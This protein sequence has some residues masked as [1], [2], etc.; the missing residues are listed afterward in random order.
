[1]CRWSPL[2]LLP[3]LAACSGKGGDT[4][5]AEDCSNPDWSELTASDGTVHVR[6][7]GSVYGDGTRGN[8]YSTIEDGLDAL[9]VEAGVDTLLIGPG[10]W[11]GTWTLGGELA[12]ATLSG[13]G[14]TETTLG[15]ESIGYDPVLRVD[16]AE[17]VSI[18]DLG[19]LN[20]VRALSVLST[21][22]EAPVEVLRASVVASRRVGVLASGAD[23]HL[24]LREVSIED[25]Q[26][27]READESFS[28]RVGFGIASTGGGVLEAREV[29]VSGSHGVGVF[30]EGLD[31]V[32]GSITLDGVTVSDTATMEEDGTLGRG[33][34][35]QNMSL[36]DI[37]TT[38]LVG[39]S[40]VGIYASRTGQVMLTDVAVAEML[41]GLTGDGTST[42]DGV[43]VTTG[44]TAGGESEFYQVEV[45]GGTFEGPRAGV[46]F[47]GVGYRESGGTASGGEVDWLAQYGAE[48][49]GAVSAEIEDLGM[50]GRLEVERGALAVDFDE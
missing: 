46:I 15:S 35:L 10:T 4:G 48:A 42:G 47:E 25:S 50:D 17:G 7:E 11:L 49:T 9:D 43:V 5:A 3:A 23:T 37:L 41:P 24:L 2:L 16:G 8:P 1:M 45:L 31:Q 14:P 40:D 39:N 13:C 33:V 6:S 12:G 32:A 38:N 21:G 29:R 36:A 44:Y 22:S 19:L 20:G 34:H 30:A 28:A 26:P 27:D 18:R